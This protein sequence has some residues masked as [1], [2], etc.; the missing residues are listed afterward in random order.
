MRA[1]ALRRRVFAALP[2]HLRRTGAALAPCKCRVGATF[3]PSQRVINEIMVRHWAVGKSRNLPRRVSGIVLRTHFPPE[4][5][6]EGSPGGSPE[7][8]PLESE[9][10]G[11]CL[12]E[13]RV[14]V[15]EGRVLARHVVCPSAYLPECISP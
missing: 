11:L 9:P 5:S 4:G 14:P 8:A 1:G 6:L 3:M 7:D 15:V 2:P 10:Q 13:G 12:V